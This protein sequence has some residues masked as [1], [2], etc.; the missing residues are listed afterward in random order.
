M[1]INYYRVFN[2]QLTGFMFAPNKFR[3][4]VDQFPT[5]KTNQL[6]ATNDSTI[7]Q[8]SVNKNK[9]HY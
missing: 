5:G 9:I 1:V 8:D 6:H 4:L 3:K 2:N 7:E